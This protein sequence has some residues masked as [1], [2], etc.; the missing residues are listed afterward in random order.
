MD[1]N[2]INLLTTPDVTNRAVQRY[3]KH[4]EAQNRWYETHKE[5]VAEKRKT[6]WRDKHPNPKPRG[7]PRKVVA[8]P[9]SSEVV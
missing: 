5:E 1:G 6:E 2:L 9:P 7:R 3:L 4:R 8:D